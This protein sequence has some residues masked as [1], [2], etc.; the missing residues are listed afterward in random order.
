MAVRL[1]NAGV[2]QMLTSVGMHRV[3][4]AKA[5]E[6]AAHVRDQGID[7]GDKDGGRHEA[8]LPVTV[9]VGTS[10][11]ARG[12]VILAHAS[13]LAVQAKHGVL[14]KAASASGL[15]VKSG[16]ASRLVN[17]TTRSGKTVRVTSA[18]AAAYKASRGSRG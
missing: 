4:Q 16:Q 6:V 9:E 13:G 3:I 10:D 7:V 15:Q 12:V 5:E 14:T 1:N 18:Q 2:R 17:Y 11:R 8:P